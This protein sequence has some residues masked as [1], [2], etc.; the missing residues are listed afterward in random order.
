MVLACK[1]SIPKARRLFGPIGVDLDAIAMSGY[2]MK[3]VSECHAISH[4]GIECRES[5]REGKAILQPRGFRDGQ[6]EKSQLGFSMW[7][8]LA[9]Y[10]IWGPL[11]SLRNEDPAPGKSMTWNSRT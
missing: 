6:R 2:A 11:L 1:V 3:Q 5:L 7:S 10:Y 9:I 4:A 8:H